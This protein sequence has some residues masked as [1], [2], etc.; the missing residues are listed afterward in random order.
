LEHF[1]DHTPAACRLYSLGFDD[2]GV[3]DISDH[4]SET[5]APATAAQ[6][7]L[8]EAA[9]RVSN[10]GSVDGGR[11]SFFAPRGSR[12]GTKSEIVSARSRRAGRLAR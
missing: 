4:G 3:P 10:A 8:L 12:G 1:L 11:T 6:S 5:S 9:L 7:T 2:D